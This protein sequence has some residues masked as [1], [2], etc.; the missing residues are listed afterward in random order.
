MVVR[1]G[2]PKSAFSSEAWASFR[3]LIAIS[4]V[5]YNRSKEILH[6][7]GHR[8]A[9]SNVFWLY[10]WVISKDYKYLIANTPALLGLHV[11]DEF[12]GQ[13][14]P[15]IPQMRLGNHDIDAPLLKE[16]I[17]RWHLRYAT[18]RPTWPERALFRSLNMAYQASQTPAVTNTT[19]YDVGRSLALWVSAFEILA[20]PGM[21]RSNT[22]AVFRLLEN[23]EWECRA[24]RSRRFVVRSQAHG[25][26]PRGPISHWLYRQMY[27]IRNDFLHGNPV[28]KHRLTIRQSKRNLFEVAAPLYRLALT[29]FLPL[30]APR[31]LPRDDPRFGESIDARLRFA[32]YQ[33]TLENSL[34][35]MRQPIPDE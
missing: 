8:I 2:A 27:A 4:V 21:G 15:E 16:L 32:S 26:G 22:D 33:R 34:E 3:D 13:S 14:S 9:F 24:S 25:A 5:P 18:S 7:R 17:A 23:V 10:P 29:G 35:A 19:I 31:L 1:D 30:H 6:R 12:R 11:A 28:T 20:H